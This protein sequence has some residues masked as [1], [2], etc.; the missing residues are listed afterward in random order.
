MVIVSLATTVTKHIMLKCVKLKTA[1][2]SIVKRDIPL[3]ASF[4]E[5]L[6]GV[7]LETTVRTDTL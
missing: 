1:E 3:T 4:T 7:S 6:E 2:S 5:A